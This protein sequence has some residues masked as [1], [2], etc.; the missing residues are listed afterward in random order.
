MDRFEHIQGCLFGTAVG[1]AI[2]LPREGLHPR[3]AKRLFGEAPLHHALVGRRGLCSDDTEHTVMVAQSLIASA[4]EAEGFRGEFSRRLRWWLVR[5]PGGVGFGTLRACVR[6]W[7]GVSSERSGVNSAGNGPAMRSAL[8]GLFAHSREHM[9]ALVKVSTRITHSDPRAEE[10]AAVVAGL[11]HMIGAADGKALTAIDIT[12]EVFASVNDHE[13]YERLQQAVELVECGREA[14]TYVHEAGLESGVSGFVNHTVPAA[15]YCWFKHQGDF[16][17]AVEAAV[18]LGGDTDTVAAI[19]GSLAGAQVGKQGIPTEW[20]NG[21]SEW[22]CTMRWMDAS[23]QRLTD[24]C[25]SG[26]VE[27][28]PELSPI[29]LF[30]RNI[31]FIVIVLL[32]A[33][34]RLLPPY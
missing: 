32:H 9:E 10:G 24:A 27:S 30:L 2:G 1:D 31:V 3:R 12:R 20:I 28:P 21:I 8:L 14:S 18:M 4:G 17:S 16:R 11:A 19:T 15:V 7:F 25:E 5:L 33:L 29:K 13:L 23:A 6:L 22:P 34:R 26:Q